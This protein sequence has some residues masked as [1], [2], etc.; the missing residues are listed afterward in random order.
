MHDIDSISSRMKKV[1]SVALCASLII[2]TAA[3][4]PL[5]SLNHGIEAAAAQTYQD[6][7]F[8]VGSDKNVTITRYTGSASFVTVP[9]TINGNPVTTI[10]WNAFS[11]CSTLKEITLPE[12]LKSIGNYAFKS[13]T[14]LER[15]TIPDSVTSVSKGAFYNCS[16]LKSVTLSASQ[17]AIPQWCFTGCSALTDITIPASVSS[18]GTYA[19]DACTSL[20]SISLPDAVTTIDQYTF[21]NCTSLRTIRFSP[22]TTEILEY[23]FSHCSSL[24]TVVIPEGVTAIGENAFEYCT[25]LDNPDLS[26]VMG[27]YPKAFIGCTGISELHLPDSLIYIGEQAFSGCSSI[28]ELTLPKEM[29]NIQSKV[30]YGCS[31]LTELELPVSIKSIGSYAFAQCTGLTGLEIPSNMT[32]IGSYAFAQCTGLKYVV[33]RHTSITIGQGAFTRTDL[34]TI[35]GKEGSDAETF[36]GN[37]NIPFV[38]DSKL[39]TYGNFQYGYI[40]PYQTKDYGLSIKK[41]TGDESDIV[42][43]SSINGTDVINFS[44]NAIDTHLSPGSFHSIHIP[45][46]IKYL[47]SIGYYNSNDMRLQSFEVDEQNNTFASRDGVLFSKDMT[48]IIRYPRGKA[49]IAYTVPDGVSEIENRAFYNCYNLREVTLPDTVTAIREYAFESDC[50]LAAI[51]IPSRFIMIEDKA[52]TDCPD[53]SIYGVPGSAAETFA[54]N[55]NI[56]FY[57]ISR[58]TSLS[59]CTIT[60]EESAAYSPAGCKPA[61]TVRHKGK[62]LTEGVD[63]TVTY[64]DN[65]AVGT[66]KIIVKGTRYYYGTIMKTFS[67]TAVD[68]NHLS[69]YYQT[70]L[71]YNGSAQVP[72][73]LISHDDTLLTENTDYTLTAADAVNAGD[74]SVTVTGTGNY[75][76]SVTLPYTIEKQK[77]DQLSVTITPDPYI[78]DPD[79]QNP[80]ITVK[81]GSRTLVQNEDYHLVVQSLFAAGTAY[82]TITGM[83][84]YTGTV[85]KALTVQKRPITSAQLT[86]STDKFTYNGQEK[87]PVP[88]VTD[89]S[90]TLTEGVDYTVAYRNHINAGT[91]EITITGIGNYSGVL[92]GT[93]T[94]A[95]RSLS[96]ASVSLSRDSFIYNGTAQEPSVVITDLNRTLTKGTDYTLSFT[97]NIHVGTAK[98]TITGMGNYKNTVSRTFTIQPRPI[99]DTTASLVSDVFDYDGTEKCPAALI[100]YGSMNLRQEDDYTIAYKQNINAGEAAAVITGTDDFTGTLELPFRIRPVD[101]TKT[102]ITLSKDSF[103]Y[104]GNA[105]YPSV[106]ITNGSLTLKKNTDYTVAYSDNI[107]AGAASVILSGSGNYTGTVTKEFTIKPKNISSAAMQL[108]IETF[109][110]N[111]RE[112]QPTPTV[113]DGDLDLE[114][115]KDYTISYRN[116]IQA[117]KGEII[118]SG[119]GDYTGELKKQ[120]TINTRNISKASVSIT[121]DTFVY[122]GTAHTPEVTLTDLGKTL[123]PE[124]DYT[125]SYEQNINA[126]TASLKITGTG[127]YKNAVTKTFTITPRSLGQTTA[128]L[129]AVSFNYDG[130]EKCPDVTITDGSKTLVKD[131]D[132][133]VSYTKNI[134]IGTASAVISGRGNYS[135]NLTRSFRI[136]E[137]KLANCTVS[138]SG[139]SFTYTGTAI[140]PAVTVKDGSKTLVQD[141]DYTVTYTSNTNAGMATAAVKGINHYAGTVDKTFTIVPEAIAESDITL[142][143]TVLTYTGNAKYPTV[144]VTHNQTVLTKNTD[145]KL[146]FADN[147]NAGTASVSI[148]FQNNYSGTFIKTYTIVPRPVTSAKAVLSDT[149]FTYDG[150]EKEPD[151]TV[152]YGNMV[153]QQGKD[154]TLSYTDHLSAGTA[155]VTII[156]KGNYSSSTDCTYTILP[157]SLGDAAVTLSPA[158]FTYN[159]TPSQ[160]D[161]TVRKNGRTLESGKDYRLTFADNTNAGTASVTVT[162]I[163]N[164]TDSVE[165]TYSI[166]T[167]D[168]AEAVIVLSEDNYLYDGTVKKPVPTVTLG[169]TVL[170]KGSDYTVT[171]K[172]NKN[173]GTANVTITGTG[174]YSGTAGTTFTIRPL[175]MANAGVTLQTTSY[176]YG[177]KERKPQVSVV[178]G[179]QTLTK[180]AHYTVRYEN[181]IAAGEAS[182]IISGINNYSGS[183]TRTF[184]ITPRAITKAS[185]TLSPEVVTYNGELQQPSVTVTDLSA[186]LKAG[187]DYTVTYSNNRSAGTAA[188]VIQGSGNY[189]GTIEKEF[190]IEPITIQDQEVVMASD[191]VTYTGNAKY[192]GITLKHDGT[193]L[194]KNTDYKLSFENNINAGTAV[195]HITCQGNYKGEFTR[196]FTIQPKRIVN[197]AITLSSTT[198]PYNGN[199]RFP[200]VTV[201]DGKTVLT[202]DKDYTVSYS[203]NTD[204]GTAVLTITGKGNYT[205]SVRKTFTIT[206]L[207]LSEA[208]VTLDQTAFTY[209]GTELT[210]DAAVVLNGY[211]LIRDQDYIITYSDN[212][213]IGTNTAKATIKGTGNYSGSVTRKFSVIPIP[214]QNADITINPS[215]DTYVYDGTEKHPAVSVRYQGKTLTAG[216]D[217]TLDYLDNTEAGNAS[218]II[219]GCGIYG[220]STSEQ[221]TILPRDIGG[222]DMILSK[223]VYTY[224]G[225][226]K[227]P[228]AT[229]AYGDKTLIKGTDYTVSYSENTN[230]GTAL[231]TVTGKGNYSGTLCETFTI[232]PKMFTSA[233]VTLSKD[234]YSYSGNAKQPGVTVVYNGQTLVN[235]TDYKIRYENNRNAGT[236]TVVVTGTGN[237]TGTIS[238]NYVINPR[239]ITKPTASLE[240]KSVEYSGNPNEPEPVVTDPMNNA[241]LT[242]GTDYTLDYRNNVN[243][244]TASVIITGKGNYTGSRTISFTITSRS[245]SNTAITLSESVMEY[246]GKQLTPKVTVKDGAL[247][248]ELIS[249]TDFTV[250]YSSNTNAGTA[251][252]TITGKGNYQGTAS[253]TFIITQRSLSDCT[254]SLSQYEYTY[255]GS[256]IIPTETVTDNGTALI[257]GKDYTIQYSNHIHTGTAGI[258]VTGCGNYSGTLTDTFHISPADIAAATITLTS[259]MAYTGEERMPPV[260][261]TYGTQTLTQKTDFSVEYTDNVEVGAA[262]VTV[263]AAQGGD[264][265]GSAVCGF[266]ITPASGENA[267]ITVAQATYDG[268]KLMPAITVRV[269]S[270]ILV[271]ETDYT[272]SYSNNVNAGN[273]AKV[274]VTFQGN[275]TG[276]KN[277]TFTIDPKPIN[278]T[279]T[280]KRSYPYQDGEPVCPEIKVNLATDEGNVELIQDV[281]DSL[282][283]IQ[284]E[285]KGNYSFTVTKTFAIT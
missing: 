96:N 7:E 68:I 165:Q 261:V 243:A 14:A 265:T 153:L 9:D 69:L 216:T 272:F 66:G 209:T 84:N 236:A 34:L 49:G 152:T 248:K 99:A 275:Y 242:E 260:N 97:Q 259:S 230:A 130:S 138:L 80:V 94:I 103:T 136:E 48:H 150:S 100:Q 86:L 15:M 131:V 186:P 60:A 200:E 233:E 281:Q 92:T 133:T 263:T 237:Y 252:V 267:V 13:C 195:V 185:V 12:G 30:F 235:N 135:G 197:A 175:D 107:H 270:R 244:G 174:N 77:V 61:V 109:T 46:T 38:D 16:G 119:K 5:G 98:L 29:T 83:G 33:I 203:G 67:I 280:S 211:T 207:S 8:T 160:P 82:I 144:T 231:V 111:A 101:L 188:V 177:A 239:S 18:I 227:T 2:S 105:K 64:S 129:S 147:V 238:R 142:G 208:D 192:P 126:G 162:G 159:G 71:T 184:T 127:N 173:A 58:S 85:K 206:P 73:V 194:T 108:D 178:Y 277:R 223:Y 6:F 205:D 213:N 88:T 148:I 106:V 240:T 20:P 55:N 218:V 137:G 285:G 219:T 54:D 90:H 182:V 42:I 167:Q 268:T 245:I 254:L 215:A 164:Y 221:F 278:P 170:K 37:N 146:V 1:L 21:H 212:I 36:A 171:Y 3:V 25:S 11:S 114:A 269:G 72:S 214:I 246:T 250:A 57:D 204:A 89:G 31:S 276:T 249:G 132:Y 179:T 4:M 156:G 191:S 78:Y 201:S 271:S 102:S 87:K 41:Y 274:K 117:G 151:V 35:H 91:G 124:Q 104:S 10:D 139:T 75:T 247:K 155:C 93:F 120:F 44:W 166:Q 39:Y 266:Q 140:T 118:L 43:P 196:A 241:V 226:V 262:V 181:N 45:S 26:S 59:D 113:K 128:V 145:Y 172:A 198:F 222:A 116:N 257:A 283:V 81:D 163:G 121:S 202:Q 176:V 27:I 190:A 210:P 217:Y 28:S 220:G 258:T 95:S 53:L 122:D 143:S 255:T 79:F 134:Q 224:S 110:Y 273:Q 22:D 76:G 112:K 180:G 65:K 157:L 70:S 256:K 161:V 158:A 17:T 74:H 187:T 199:P 168:I 154:Y 232:Q 193:V 24:E 228:L 50:S 149:V 284:V 234:S 51:I 56:P 23:A 40:R 279:I 47:T 282:A 62:L 189:T 52:F 225:N 251:T 253:R 183:I 141:T 264:F 115:E 63:Y 229:V 169:N 19:F 123:V 125:V 32:S